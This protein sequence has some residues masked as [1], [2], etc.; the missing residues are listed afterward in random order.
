LRA[1]GPS[2]EPTRGM[3]R[4]AAPKKKLQTNGMT[5]Q[6]IDGLADTKLGGA[7]ALQGARVSPKGL[8]KSLYARWE[9]LADQEAFRRAPGLILCRLISWW[10]RCLLQQSAIIRLPKWGVQMFLPAEWRGLPKL[11]FAFREY[12]EP[13]LAC[14]EE[15]L[16]PGKTF[17]DA[18]ANVGIYT[19]A[20]SRIVGKTGRVFA[21]EP[22]MQSLPA[23]QRNIALNRLTNVVAFPVALSH[24]TAAAKLYH[25]PNPSLNSLGKETAWSEESEEITTERLDDILERAC[26]DHVD[27]IKVDVQGAEELVL[28]GARKVLSSMHPTIIFEIF[29][30]GTVPLRLAPYGAWEF[31]ASLG[32]EFSVVDW[33][34]GLRRQ[35][36]PPGIRNVVA[37]YR[38]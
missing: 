17:V 21:F 23:L 1:L 9:Y 37:T 29:P 24:V 36:R 18:G 15:V 16:S 26:I 2:P 12:Y 32:Y 6:A 4:P 30:E 11:I 13:E 31:L 35:E 22:S 8:V 20:A 28:R 14:L 38:Q 3:K 7:E 27:V 33:R 19:L 25:G 10:I 5:V 34:E